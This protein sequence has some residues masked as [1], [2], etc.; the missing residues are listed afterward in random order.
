VAKLIYSTIT[1]LDGFVADADGDFDWAAPD[2]AVHGFVNDLEREVGTYLYGRRM[3]EV[4]NVWQTMDGE[5]G[6]THDYAQ[7]WRG[8]DKIVFSTTLDA[9]STPRTRLERSFD[10]DAVR[11]FVTGADRDVSLGGPQLAGAALRAG[12]VDELHVFQNPIIVGGGNHF[13]PGGVQIELELVAEHRFDNGVV[14][15]RYSVRS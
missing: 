9:V 8:A 15:L 4:M 11:G 13:L 2:E 7:I 14:Y 6:V 1:S 10:A 12:I 3:Y 5:S